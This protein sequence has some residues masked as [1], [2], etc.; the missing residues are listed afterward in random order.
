MDRYQKSYAFQQASV[1]QGKELGKSPRRRLGSKGW[2]QSGL[3]TREC[4]IVDMSGHGAQ[5]E[6]DPMEHIDDNFSLLVSRD[7]ESS[8]RCQIRWRCGSLIG[9]EFCSPERA[10]TVFMVN[11]PEMKA[12][13]TRAL[14]LCGHDSH[15]TL[16]SGTLSR[17]ASI[18]P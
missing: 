14:G 1:A 4:I 6:I 11:R 7:H 5:I 13:M 10:P 3:S 17:Q 9:A 16:P 18:R 8:L 2:I 12:L 15:A